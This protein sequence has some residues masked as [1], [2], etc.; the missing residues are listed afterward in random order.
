MT[1]LTPVPTSRARCRTTPRS[2]SVAVSRR[3]WRPS[4]L[5]MPTL[6]SSVEDVHDRAAQPDRLAELDLVVAAGHPHGHVLADEPAA[7]RDGG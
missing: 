7:V 2:T 4:R 1:C 5:L 3:R 6:T